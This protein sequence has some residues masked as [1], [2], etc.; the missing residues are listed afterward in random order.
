M[1]PRYY[2]YVVVALFSASM[3]CFWMAYWVSP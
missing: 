3:F 1:I 2:W